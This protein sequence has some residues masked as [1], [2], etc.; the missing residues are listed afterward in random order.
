MVGRYFFR[1]IFLT[2]V[3]DGYAANALRTTSSCHRVGLLCRDIRYFHQPS[4]NTF[5]TFPT[6]TQMGRLRN[7]AKT[8]CFKLFERR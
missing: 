4:G 1:M 8:I 2:R 7:Q 3:R 6:S 5:L